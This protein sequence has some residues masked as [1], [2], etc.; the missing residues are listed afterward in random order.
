MGEASFI[1]EDGNLAVKSNG[2][3]ALNIISIIN[4]VVQFPELSDSIL[5]WCFSE[6]YFDELEENREEEEE[7]QQE[8]ENK[9]KQLEFLKA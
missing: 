5:A 8:I 4:K 7:K 3:V 6:D 1:K 2:Q 9:L